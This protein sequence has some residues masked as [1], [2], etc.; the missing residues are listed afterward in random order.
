MRIFKQKKGNQLLKYYNKILLFSSNEKG[1][2][3]DKEI[4]FCD[5]FMKIFSRILQNFGHK[6]GNFIIQNII[7]FLYLLYFYHFK[8]FVFANL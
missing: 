8:F 4:Y 2:L 1:K 3:C 6:K 5:N 7:Q